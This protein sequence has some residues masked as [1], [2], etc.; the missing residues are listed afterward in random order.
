LGEKEKGFRDALILETFFQVVKN[1]PLSSIAWLSFQDRLLRETAQARLGP[2]S[3][4]YLLESIDALKGLID[5]PGSAV[6]EAFIAQL[7]PRAE[8]VF[9]KSGDS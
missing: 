3:N 2:V 4:V 6:D 7:T 8:Q 5:T 9:F 1:S